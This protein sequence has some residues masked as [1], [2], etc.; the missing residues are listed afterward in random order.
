MEKL[1]EKHFVLGSGEGN[2]ISKVLYQIAEKANQK[3]GKQNK[4]GNLN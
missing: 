3:T 1:N 4:N 2:S